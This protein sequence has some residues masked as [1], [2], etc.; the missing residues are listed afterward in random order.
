MIASLLT[1]QQDVQ[2][3]GTQKFPKREQFDENSEKKNWR[4]GANQMKVPEEYFK[5]WLYLIKLSPFLKLLG[6]AVPFATGN[7][8]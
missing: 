2:G 5:I 1:Y 8:Q 4:N 3:N 7:F 6:H